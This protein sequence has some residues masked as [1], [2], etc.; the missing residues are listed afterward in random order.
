LEII[1][2]DFETQIVNIRSDI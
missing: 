2:K 1:D